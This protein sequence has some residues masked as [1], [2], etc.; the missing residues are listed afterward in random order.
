MG[1]PKGNKLMLSH[2]RFN[3]LKKN[4][5]ATIINLKHIFTNCVY[6]NTLKK[7]KN[8]FFKK[9]NEFKQNTWCKHFGFSRI[10]KYV[11]R[12]WK[13]WR[14]PRRGYYDI[15]KGIAFRIA[16]IPFI[17]KI[18]K[19][20]KR[21]LMYSF[22]KKNLYTKDCVESRNKRIRFS[23]RNPKYKKSYN[24]YKNKQLNFMQKT[25]W[26]FLTNKNGL[27]CW[28]DFETGIYHDSVKRDV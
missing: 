21:K 7:S 22:I 15:R 2:G 5:C 8:L 6:T 19:N 1:A 18:N 17:T 11:I 24:K 13:F 28:W 20:L 4:T 12:E 9:H 14:E 25:H 3:F 27:H 16:K 26:L 10:K 23:F